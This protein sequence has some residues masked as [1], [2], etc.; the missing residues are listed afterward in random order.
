MVSRL[1]PFLKKGVALSVDDS[2]TIITIV[3]YGQH[4]TRQVLRLSFISAN[5]CQLF[6]S[7]R[8][9]YLLQMRLP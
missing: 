4:S 1:F 6:Y 7:V 2:L 9:P 5:M 3:F 8:F